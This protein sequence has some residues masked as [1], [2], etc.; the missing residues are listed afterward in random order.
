MYSAPL[1]IFGTGSLAK[2]AHY[3]LT[4]E[5]GCT[6]LKFTVDAD[7]KDADTICDTPIITWDE[8]INE[9]SQDEIAMHVAIGYRDMQKRQLIF[10][11]ARKQGYSLENVISS[12]AFIAKTAKIGV[13]N[14]IMPGAVIEPGVSLGSNNVVWS[15]TVICHDTIIGDHNFFASNVTIGGEVIIGHRCFFGFS[16][17]VAQQRVIADDVLLAAQSLLLTDGNSKRRYQG[18]PAK[19]LTGISF[20]TGICI[21]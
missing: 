15:N 1:I 7:R 18:I 14:F 16:S 9:H 11:R 20:E 17:T 4:H 21:E 2:L 10:E 12:S 6:A 3:Y 8:C 13:N 19:A 5:M